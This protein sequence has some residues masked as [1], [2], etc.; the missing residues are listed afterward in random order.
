[1]KKENYGGHRDR[2]LLFLGITVM[3]L[4]L[5]RNSVRV[6]LGESISLIGI[7]GYFT[8]FPAFFLLIGSINELKKY[9]VFIFFFCYLFLLMIFQISE[10]GIVSIVG[11]CNIFA[12]MFFFLTLFRLADDKQYIFEHILKLLIIVV[13]INSIGGLLQ[14]TISINI[15]GLISN[16]IYANAEVMS[17][18]SVTPRLISF[19]SSP[20]SLAVALA[21]GFS[22]AT[23]F[24]P[25]EY[26]G[27]YKVMAMILIFITGALTLSKAFF[28]FLF[29]VFFSHAIINRSILLPILVI[30]GISLLSFHERFQRIFL[31]DT[32]ISDISTYSAFKYWIEG[33]RDMAQIGNLFFGKGL[34][35]YSR[36]GQIL[37]GSD[38]I[39]G[40]ESY[41]IQIFAETGL[42]GISSLLL[43]IICS[44]KR[45]FSNNKL[46]VP[47]ILAFLVNGI[48]SPALYG[49]LSG[50][51]F[52]FVIV[53]SFFIQRK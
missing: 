52:S 53:S 21:F 14:G 29:I 23:F 11:F 7:A 32:F 18:G 4:I 20:Q 33:F 6:F 38:E 19:I 46:L 47:I 45:C 48:F 12:P 10:Q 50:T 39:H 40:V 2:Y 28:L 30:G 25:K 51:L 26:S 3:L 17:K 15:F 16:D 31:A 9:F 36:G 1:M 34:G 5:F 13:L 49:Y 37:S 27:L 42:I 35:I 41:I 8:L 43:I 22:L 44:I 24:W